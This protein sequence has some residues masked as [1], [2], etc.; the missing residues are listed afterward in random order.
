MELWPA[1]VYIS[2]LVISAILCV[3]G[4]AA[5]VSVGVVMSQPP[6]GSKY[7]SCYISNSSFLPPFIVL[8]STTCRDYIYTRASKFLNEIQVH[9]EKQLKK[10]RYEQQF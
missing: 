4:V 5:C 8:M 10:L 7:K 3:I 9:V 1:R 6:D 2:L